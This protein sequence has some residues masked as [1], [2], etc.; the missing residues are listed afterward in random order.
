MTLIKKTWKTEIGIALIAIGGA[1]F[2]G[3]EVTPETAVSLDQWLKFFGTI[4]F[5]AGTSLVGYRVSK[6][7]NEITKN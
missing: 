4:I 5:S 7:F 1:L 2:A 3:S 6:K